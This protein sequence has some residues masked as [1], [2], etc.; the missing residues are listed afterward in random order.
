MLLKPFAGA[1]V[2]ALLAG[3]AGIEAARQARESDAEANAAFP[4]NYRTEI[5]ALMRTYLNDP[6]GVREAVVT[7]PAIRTIDGTTRYMSC[8]RYNARK[9]GGQY[10][11]RKD[12]I[13]VYRMGKLE[14]IVD[15]A[16]DHCRDAAYQPFPEL[17][18]LAR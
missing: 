6:T 3:C 8:L 4:Q 2:A 11:G 12:S 13:V 15:N 17:Q 5:A 10:A 1:A 18:R 16:R 7:V 9:D 14:R